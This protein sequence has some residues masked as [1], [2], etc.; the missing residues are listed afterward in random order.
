M[1]RII[2]C[3]LTLSLAATAAASDSIS[4]G[5]R[6]GAVTGRDSTYTEAFADL[7]LNRLVSIG[8]T[9]AYVAVDREH[10]TTVKRDESIPITALFKLHA[11]IPVL[12]PYAGLGAAL[13][14]HD[15]RGVKGTPVA[16]VGGDMRI[17]TTPLFLN[18][19]YRRQFD[20]ELNILAGGIGIRF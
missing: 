13:V 14:F 3:L 6:A 11:P 5:A 19:E 15:E 2:I 10:A 4:I 8:A 16:L 20:D 18:I 17:A 12:Q 9:L 7:H 1:K